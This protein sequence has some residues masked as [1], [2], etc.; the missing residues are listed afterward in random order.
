M[1]KRSVGLILVAMVTIVFV[2]NCKNEVKNKAYYF[3][4][5]NHYASQKQFKK[6]IEYFEK[7][8]NDFDG[9]AYR[10]R[11]IFMVGYIYANEINDQPGSLEKA[12][13]YYEMFLKEFPSHELAE[14]VRMEIQNLG[15]DPNEIILQKVEK[16]VESSVEK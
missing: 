1:L 5:A 2:L 9:P 6:A 10:A 7:V 15:K 4:Q 3:Q 14:S 11:S 12:K 13:E 16:D 8:I